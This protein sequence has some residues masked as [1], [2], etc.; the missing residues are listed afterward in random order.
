M[1]YMVFITKQETRW[2]SL[3]FGA[4]G[5]QVR[6]S[7]PME[8]HRVLGLLH[9]KSYV[10][11]K[12]PPADVAWRGCQLIFVICPLFKFTRSEPRVASRRDYTKFNTKT[13]DLNQILDNIRQREIRLPACTS[14][15]IYSKLIT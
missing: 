5:S 13:V 12:R 7:I 8:I 11:V 3:D 2:P 1:K 4:G 15:R 14:A 6:N 10:V 9:P